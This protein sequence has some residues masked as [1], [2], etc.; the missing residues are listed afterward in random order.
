MDYREIRN[1]AARR[2]RILLNELTPRERKALIVIVLLIIMGAVAK[3]I[4]G[5]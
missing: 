5:A 1:R 4:R 2:S 3:K